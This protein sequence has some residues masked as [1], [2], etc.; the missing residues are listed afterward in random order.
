MIQ[1]SA[2]PNSPACAYM[3]LATLLFF[4][5][6]EVLLLLVNNQKNLEKTKNNPQV[7]PRPAPPWLC[8]FCFLEVL[9]TFGQK[10]KK[11]LRKPTKKTTQVLPRPAPLWFCFFVFCFLEER[12]TW[13]VFLFFLFFRFSHF[14]TKNQVPSSTSPP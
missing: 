10:P 2:D 14:K 5:F 3:G 4:C 12:K 8:F 13:V 6:L 11:T 1:C 9:A 7:F